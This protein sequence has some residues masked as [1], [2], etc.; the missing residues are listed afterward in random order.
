MWQLVQR[1][2]L[3]KR[4]G[5]GTANSAKLKYYSAGVVSHNIDLYGP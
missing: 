5:N 2:Y 4:F 3:E 1:T